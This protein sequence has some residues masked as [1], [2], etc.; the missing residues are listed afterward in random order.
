MD[1]IVPV[2]IDEKETDMVG[3]EDTVLHREALLVVAASDSEGVAV[4]LAA[5]RVTVNFWLQK[6]QYIGLSRRRALDWLL[7]PFMGA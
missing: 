3:E 2:D 4:P 1:A 5:Q 7:L 6:T